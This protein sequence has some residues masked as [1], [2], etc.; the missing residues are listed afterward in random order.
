[1]TLGNAGFSAIRLPC[2]P[3]RSQALLG[4]SLLGLAFLGVVILGVVILGLSFLDMEI[5]IND[6]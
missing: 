5:V 6:G 1:M 2:P 3:A 4:L